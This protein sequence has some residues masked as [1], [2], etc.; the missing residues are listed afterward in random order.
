MNTY[1]PA[2]PPIYATNGAPEPARV[3]GGQ[4]PAYAPPPPPP[5]APASAQQPPQ[6]G[7]LSAEQEALLASL[8]GQ[9]T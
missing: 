8:T 1:Q 6:Y 3:N 2:P 9:A 4:P 7:P 5:V